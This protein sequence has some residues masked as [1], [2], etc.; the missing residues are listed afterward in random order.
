MY[1]H[2]VSY[3]P[4]TQTNATQVSVQLG[5]NQVPWC[6]E[7]TFSVVS[8]DQF[9]D[10][11]ACIS[12]CA[13]STGSAEAAE[14]PRTLP[15]RGSSNPTSLRLS[16]ARDHVRRNPFIC[17][18]SRISPL[19]AKQMGLITNPAAPFDRSCSF[20]TPLAFYSMWDF[21]FFFFNLANTMVYSH[22]P[23]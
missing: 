20:K 5:H 17:H 2:D 16:F 4:Q 14:A 21:L 8:P 13:C 9:G 23:F 12:N 11:S 15:L 3:R 18:T 22:F 7:G 1:F 10:S 19:C 6:W